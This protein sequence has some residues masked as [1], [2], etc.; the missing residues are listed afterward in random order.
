MGQPVR[1]II[2]DTHPELK[3]E[4]FITLLVDG[5]NLLRICFADD[6][7]NSDGV[8]YGG[9]FQ[10][11]LQLREMIK[12]I[13]NRLAYIY[14]FFDGHKSGLERYKIYNGYKANREDKDYASMLKETEQDLEEKSEYWKQFNALVDKMQKKHFKSKYNSGRKQ[15]LNAEEKRY[16]A[17]YKVR[18][19]TEAG[20]FKI[21]E[22]DRAKEIIRV[23]EK[24]MLDENF[25]RE[26]DI[27][28]KCFNELYIRWIFDDNDA[29]EGDDYISYYVKNK[30]PEE[31]III[32]STDEDITQLISDTVCI[33]DKKKNSYVS[34][35]NYLKLKGF[36]Y[37][38]VVLKKII[39][40][41]TSDNIKNISGVSEKRLLEL[42]P[43]I[44]TR[45][46]TLDEVKEKAQ[47]AIDE[48]LSQKKNPLQWHK[49][50]VDGVYN[51]EYEG[52]IYEINEKLVDLSNP[53]ITKEAKKELD[54]MMYTSQDTEG[55]SFENLYKIMRE[56][57]IEEL[58]DE[59]KFS[60]FFEPFKPIVN[61]EI[62]KF[63]KE[64]R[65]N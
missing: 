8:H 31:R 43:E 54:S 41:D 17:E 45:K 23:A 2:K 35:K 58:C 53:L 49:N 5:N 57:K 13:D 14:V 34:H 3:N 15:P 64:N 42:V 39:C 47:Q 24:E 12:K 19:I 33:Y 44:A 48:R 4:T 50:I 22:Q 27:L 6:K 32:M 30:K 16:V 55:R 56:E 38:N 63:N 25:A 51:G 62:T 40:G 65:K 7:L 36:T 61:K 21:F 1:N 59:K 10:F 52:D 18:N 46:V 37:E 20:L 60:T 28:L 29:T 9:V 11:L 26:R